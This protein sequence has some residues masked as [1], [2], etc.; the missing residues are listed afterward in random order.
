M[1]PLQVQAI[2][3]SHMSLASL[4]PHPSQTCT[5][6]LQTLLKSKTLLQQPTHVVA[7]SAGAAGAVFPAWPLPN[8]FPTPPD[9]RSPKEQLFLVPHTPIYLLTNSEPIPCSPNSHPILTSTATAIAIC[10][11][12][13]AESP[14]RA[15]A[16]LPYILVHPLATS[17]VSPPSPSKPL[18]RTS[19]KGHS[20]Q[21]SVC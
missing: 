16:S 2:T 1:V 5:I 3:S 4:R 19:M 7:A 13:T 21:A 18:T 8:I 15:Y 14:P 12:A 17:E 9:L 6:R 20:K 11:I 10:A